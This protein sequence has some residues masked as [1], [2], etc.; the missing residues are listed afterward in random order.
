ML[1][2]GR[3]GLV[4]ATQ[5]NIAHADTECRPTVEFKRSSITAA[6]VRSQVNA[7]ITFKISQIF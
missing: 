1:R 2:K 3:L 7:I 5:F 4:P 6:I